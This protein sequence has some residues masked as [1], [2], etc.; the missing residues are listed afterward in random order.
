VEHQES[1]DKSN[2]ISATVQGPDS[3]ES[4]DATDVQ[5]VMPLAGL[6]DEQFAELAASILVVIPHRSN[7][8]IGAGICTHF[9]M[10]GRIGLRVATVKDP[11]GGFIECTRGGIVQLFLE[12]AWKN[13]DIKYLVMI[14]ND[15]SIQWDAPLRLAQHEKPVVSGVVCGYNAERGIFACFTAKDENGIARFPSYRDTKFLPAEGLIEVEQAGTG[16]V[17]VRR[18]VLEVIR[19]N[20]EQPFMIPEDVR[21]EGIRAGQLRKSEDICFCER[22]CK[23]GFGRYVDLSIHATH[24]KT[25]PI[26]WPADCIDDTI[27]AIDW[28]PSAFDY[29]GVM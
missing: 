16:L 9:G 3:H 12:T 21:V 20:G 7:E 27:S 8:G 24:F 10:W 28:K 18:D 23:Y 19:E 29:K 25:V 4:E 15:Q 26:G 13:P 5:T 2:Y 11:H 22:V 1:P 17:C 6:T 14:D